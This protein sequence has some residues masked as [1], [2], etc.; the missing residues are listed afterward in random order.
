MSRLLVDGSVK[1]VSSGEFLDTDPV[2]VQPEC[3]AGS[4][5][6]GD[7]LDVLD[8]LAVETFAH[9]LYNAD[10]IAH[11]FRGFLRGTGI[12]GGEVELGTPTAPSPYLINNLAA[13]DQNQS[14]PLAL[15]LMPGQRFD[16]A[17]FEGVHAT[18]PNYN[19]NLLRAL[20]QALVVRGRVPG[21]QIDLVNDGQSSILAGPPAGARLRRV[22]ASP[23]GF[24]LGNT[25]SFFMDRD[26]AAGG[27]LG[28]K[29]VTITLHDPINGDRLVDTTAVTSG[30][31][32]SYPLLGFELESGQSLELEV[33]E[34]THVTDP[35]MFWYYEDLL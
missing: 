24:Q 1:Q 3:P 13:A 29:T 20:I 15:S 27:D 34:A 31:L 9:V 12:P 5:L 10:D 17:M 4:Q 16:L 33:A 18:P 6:V 32:L 14:V 30:Q 11:N 23:V 26:Y 21:N 28:A 22:C 25:Q 7:V 35:V 2:S 8:V 19:L